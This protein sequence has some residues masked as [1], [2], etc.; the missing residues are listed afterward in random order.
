MFKKVLAVVFICGLIIVWLKEWALIVFGI[1]LLLFLIRKLA[2][3]YWW[4]KDKD[5]W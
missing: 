2:D 1:I 3:V 4:G 5:K